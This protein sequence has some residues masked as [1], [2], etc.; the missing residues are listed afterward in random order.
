MEPSEVLILGTGS[1]ARFL[2]LLSAL[3]RWL[4]TQYGT[5]EQQTR[6]CQPWRVCRD[7]RRRCNFPPMT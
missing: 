3:L 5:G 1:S 7:E 2:A 4:E 6:L